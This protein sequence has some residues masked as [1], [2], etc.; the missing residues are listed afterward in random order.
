MSRIRNFI[1]RDKIKDL[2]NR[3]DQADETIFDTYLQAGSD[4]DKEGIEKTRE[5]ITSW[6]DKL[7]KRVLEFEQKQLKELADANKI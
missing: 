1:E 3:L 4:S 2:I 7:N 5:Y 6:M